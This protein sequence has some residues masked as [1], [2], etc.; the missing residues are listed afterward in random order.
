MTIRAA[1]G[2]GSNLGDRDA[3]IRAAIAGLDELGTLLATSSLYSTA[4]VGGPPQDDYVNAV[5]LLDTNL[6]P[7]ALLEGA[8]RIERSM[9][10][11]RRERWGPRTIDVDIL[12]YGDQTVDD[13][14][15]TIPHPELTK[16]RFVLEPLVEVWPDAK[17]PDGTVLAPLLAGVSSQEVH[18]IGSPWGSRAA[19]VLFALVAA[20]AV[21]VWWLVGALL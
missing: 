13:T 14:G 11:E 18:R 3:N 17:L 10:R 7:Q 8:M 20:A 12:L 21:L 6:E 16:R 9:G 5:V 2:L 1:I 15:L 19:L 4:P